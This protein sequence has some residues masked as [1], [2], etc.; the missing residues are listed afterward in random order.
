MRRSPAFLF[1]LAALVSCG[2]EGA[3]GTPSSGAA[4]DALTERWSTTLAHAPGTCTT[5]A[6][7][8]CFN[9]GI[10]KAHGCGGVT[11]RATAEALEQVRADFAKAQCKSGIDCGAW[12][13]AP[14]CAAGRCTNG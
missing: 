13:C 8:A 4:C 9:G 1:A 5:A 14:K 7:C 2:R 12:A 11:D 10:E 6:D 3:N